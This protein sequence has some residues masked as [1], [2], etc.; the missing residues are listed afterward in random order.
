MDILGAV[1]PLTVTS[2]HGLATVTA[3]GSGTITLLAGT[4]TGTDT[5]HVRDATGAALDVPLRVLL[6]AA[7]LPP[8]VNLKITGDADATWLN[9]QLTQ[10]VSRVLQLQP[11]ATVSFGT[12]AVNATATPAP[13]VTPYAVPVHVSGAGR[14]FDV[15]AQAAVNVTTVETNAFAPPTL[16]YDD[17]PE[18]V[19]ADGVLFRGVVTPDKPV[20]L[21]Y[22]HQITGA[23]RRIVV[24]FAA[25]NQAASQVQVTD[26]TA[27]PNVDVMT[28]GHAVTRNFLLMK[29]RNEGVIYDLNAGAPVALHDINATDKQVVAGN[30]DL[31]VLQGAPVSI[32]VIAASSGID[33][34]TLI[35]GAQLPSDGHHRGGT[36]DVSA[37]GFDNRYFS[38][39]GADSAFAIGAREH[40]PQAV[41]G[42][43]G[44]DYGD[45]GVWHTVA[46]TLTNPTTAPSVAY[47]YFRP[48]GGVVRSSFLIDGQLKELGC[49][50]VASPYQLAQYTLTPS[51]TARV[52]VQT[53]T[54]GGS[55]YPAEIGFSATAPTP[56]P[57][58]VSAPDGCFPKPQAPVATPSPS[59]GA[60]P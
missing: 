47:L 21:Y 54:D 59:P 50:R 55:N 36:F 1:L 3:T 39:G 48:L 20:R 12:P 11:G 58:P 31:R 15:D 35:G 60:T 44:T 23:P 17:D 22:Y 53:M 26:S 34:L 7:S 4:Q 8:L 28:V 49:V 37:V 13:Q 27:G 9:A 10:A 16:F 18:K 56:S 14:Y 57:P 38:A 32:T 19:N 5:L 29:P 25:A 24:A 6:D 42:S 52:V 43:T 51:S 30:I 46:F 2:D 33:P 41:D 40:S 45:Y